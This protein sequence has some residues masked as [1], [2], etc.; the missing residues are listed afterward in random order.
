[1]PEISIILPTYNEC[2][3]IEN[4]IEDILNNLRDPLEIIVV[5]DNSPDGTWKIVEEMS[6][7]D[8]N[9]K[10]LR[11]LNKKGLASALIDGISFSQG[12]II[13]WMDADFSMP[14]ALISKM[15][16][17]LKDSDIAVGSRYVEGGLDKRD[18]M[19]RIFLSRF[20]NNFAPRFLGLCVKDLTSGFLAVRREV[21]N[22]VEVDGRYGEYC[23][24]FLYH[25]Q[26]A[27]LNVKEVPYCCMPRR[28]GK[29]KINP[30]L[31]KFVKCGI[32]YLSTIFRL[33]FSN[34][35]R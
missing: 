30:N 25:A 3:N 2:E 1:M 19:L 6:R 27:G 24:S 14:P 28:K 31:F 17:V 9:I 15:V 23:V 18:S 4:I 29:S 8:K 21:F 35:I 32:R 12:R 22:R 33:R 11:R 20:F 7:T 16:E 5:D 26:K 10:L 34:E 13:V